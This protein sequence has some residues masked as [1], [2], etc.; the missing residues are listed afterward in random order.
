VVGN[1]LVE[2]VV[3]GCAFALT[4]PIPAGR[5]V[6]AN[7]S[8]LRRSRAVNT[9]SLSPFRAAPAS[10]GMFSQAVAQSGAEGPIDRGGHVTAMA[11][12][13]HFVEVW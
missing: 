9:R 7:L 4:A 5:P 1:A 10:W 8:R 13:G 12:S 3:W 6:V 11:Q 2:D